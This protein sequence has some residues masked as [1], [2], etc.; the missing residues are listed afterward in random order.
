MLLS[1]Y[2][3]VVRVGGRVMWS[4]T[5]VEAVSRSIVI[6]LFWVTFIYMFLSDACSM[7]VYL[8][9]TN[10]P[11]ARTAGAIVA[12]TIKMFL[13]IWVFRKTPH[14]VIPFRMVIDTWRSGQLMPLNR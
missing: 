8:Q 13:Y 7:Y 10:K 4:G 6:I 11:T 5:C 12:Q 14:I 1:G 2:D 9:N 3:G